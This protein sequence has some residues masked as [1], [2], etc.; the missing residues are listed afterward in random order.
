MIVS[1]YDKQQLVY[2]RAASAARGEN[3]TPG[4]SQAKQSLSAVH[5]VCN[6]GDKAPSQGR[7]PRERSRRRRQIDFGVQREA[8]EGP[9]MPLLAL[10][11]LA[12][13]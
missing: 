1:V 9:P 4:L 6:A 8:A 7:R 13:R 10:V 3:K 5:G 11:G 12:H 2:A